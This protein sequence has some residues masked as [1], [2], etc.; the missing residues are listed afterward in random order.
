MSV[1]QRNIF[2]TEPNEHEISIKDHSRR[3]REKGYINKS[4]KLLGVNNY[5]VEL[6]KP[7]LL[8]LIDMLKDEYDEWVEDLTSRTLNDIKNKSD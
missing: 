8:E 5:W 3:L 7:E 6:T 1:E 4:T 2:V